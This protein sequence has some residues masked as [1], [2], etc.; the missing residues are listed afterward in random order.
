M[1]QITLH[2]VPVGHVTLREL[3]HFEYTHLGI[4]RVEEEEK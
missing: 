1:F 2:G 4:K 3:G